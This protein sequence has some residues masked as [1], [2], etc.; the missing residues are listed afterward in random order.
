MGGHIGLIIMLSFKGTVSRCDSKL[1]YTE[2][3]FPKF[4][5]KCL[6]KLKLTVRKQF[7]EEISNQ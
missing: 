6:H 2:E 3:T 4:I 7:H 5:G 1:L